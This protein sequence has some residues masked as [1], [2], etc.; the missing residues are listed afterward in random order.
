MIEKEKIRQQVIPKLGVIFLG[1]RRPG[2]DMDWGKRME[3]RTRGWLRQ[4]GLRLFEA[5]E[6]AVDDASLRRV[7]QQCKENGAEALVLLQT[8]M[9]DGRLAPTLAQLWPD[10]PLFWATPEN[11]EGD[12]ISSCS[13]VGRIFGQ[14]HSAR[15]GIR[16]KSFTATQR[17]GKRSNG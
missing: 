3:E 5:T 1:R 6:K 14:R 4:S 9:G 13:L 11:P 12:M 17:R 15:W 2:F 8:T 10:V 7:V 16:L